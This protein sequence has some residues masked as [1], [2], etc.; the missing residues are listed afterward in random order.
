MKSGCDKEGCT[1][2]PEFQVQY[3]D[4]WDFFFACADHLGECMLEEFGAYNLPK[5]FIVTKFDPEGDRK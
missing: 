3:A 1:K 5:D 2:V 4:P